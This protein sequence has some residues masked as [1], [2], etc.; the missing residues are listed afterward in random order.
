MIFLEWPTCHS[1]VRF[2]L[3]PSFLLNMISQHDGEFCLSVTNRKF[4]RGI[5]TNRLTNKQTRLSHKLLILKMG[6][7]HEISVS[8]TKTCYELLVTLVSHKSAAPEE[9]LCLSSNLQ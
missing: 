1:N 6:N 4:T 9:V 2:K 3:A 5:R 7:P 8:E